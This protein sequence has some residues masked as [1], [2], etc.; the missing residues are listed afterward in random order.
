MWRN[1]CLSVL[2]FPT[3][4]FVH[5]LKPTLVHRPQLEKLAWS[6]S[7]TP[8][9]TAGSNAELDRSRSEPARLGLQVSEVD[10]LSAWVASIMVDLDCYHKGHF[11]SLVEEACSSVPVVCRQYG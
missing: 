11:T 9:E 10:G 6:D 1:I 4:V 5:H 7:S 8:T 3:H 2:L